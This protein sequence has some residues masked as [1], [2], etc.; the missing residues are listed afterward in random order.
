MTVTRQ[1]RRVSASHE[2]LRERNDLNSPAPSRGPSR[3]GTPVSSSRCFSPDASLVLIGIRGS[4]KRSL[5]LIAA[6]AL[7]RRL[8]TE[9]HFFHET[10]GLTRQEFLQ[11][12]GKREFQRQE[13]QTTKKMLDEN[14]YNSVIECGLSSLITSVQEHL[15]EF[16]KTHPVVYLIR[17]MTEI[18]QLLK[19]DNRSTRLLASSDPRHRNCSNFEY[20]NLEDYSTRNQ[21]D[22]Q[23][24]RQSP[25][26]SFKLKQSKEDFTSFVRQITGAARLSNSVTSP[27]SLEDVPVEMRPYTHA[28]AIPFSWLLNSPDLGQLESSGDAVEI[29]LDQWTSAHMTILTRQVARL[30]RHVN[31]P[32]VVS[33]DKVLKQP[34]VQFPGSY[35]LYL[36]AVQHALRLGVDF[37]SIDIT[38]DADDFRR[39]ASSKGL[40]KI[41]G[42]CIEE[43][44]ISNS[45]SH[46]SWAEKYHY[47]I[48]LDSDVVRLLK[49][50]ATREENLSV[51][52]FAHQL[53]QNKSCKTPLI[54]YNLGTAG[55]TSRLFNPILSRVTH[56]LLEKEAAPMERTISSRSAI[57]AL[58]ASFVLDPLQ[59]FIFGAS[60]L[61]SLSPPMHNA[62]YA[63]CGL[64]HRYSARN[65]KDVSEIV[66]LA[67][68]PHFGGAS[69]VRP[70]KVSI[71]EKLSS[72]SKHAEAIGAVNTMIPLRALDSATESSLEQHANQRNRAGD[73][74]GWYGDNTDWIGIMV[75]L[76]RCLTP[77]N[78]IRPSRTTGLVIGAGGMARA[79]VYGM[80]RLGCRRIFMYNRTV[81]N[82][83]SVASHFNTRIAN[84]DDKQPQQVRVLRSPFETWPQEESPP[85]MI[86]SCV[87]AHSI[88]GQPEANFEMPQQWLGSRSG[89][90]VIDLAYKPLN[91][92]LLKQMRRFRQETGSP[93]VVVNGLET[94]PEQAIAQYEIFTGRKAPRSLMRSECHRSYTSEEV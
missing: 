68:D 40:T 4:G 66:T 65:V 90:V 15:R 49:A 26:Y 80:M 38:I 77:Q 58:V 82:A 44:G 21:D 50:N 89:G 67:Q 88:D 70:F 36:D 52:L 76:N 48:E 91:T 8:V 71:M 79:A 1:N 93:W 11:K 51:Q 7:G 64:T 35:R 2:D 85:T 56:P 16:A 47:A 19:L 3:E 33:A 54:A 17:D 18:Q 94:L 14:S 6:A 62:G 37:V 41:I 24:D 9:D 30:R 86:V 53:R 63:S 10:N 75:V 60:V 83:E 23:E 87:P 25:A 39:L 34:I 22:G 81:S 45:W 92:P 84:S 57:E 13:I 69:I 61:Y 28:L 12:H 42:F 46:S 27:F 20:F 74:I 59:F 78:V 29:V 31:A 55:M 32:I 5:G 73:V 43:A 72:W